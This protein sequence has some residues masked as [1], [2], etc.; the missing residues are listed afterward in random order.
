M[1]AP[2]R[3]CTLG[4][5][6]GILRGRPTAWLVVVVACALTLVAVDAGPGT[7][8][9]TASAE[10]VRNATIV[11]EEGGTRSGFATPE[12]TVGGGGTVTVVNLDSMD[13]TVTSVARAADGTPLF[14]VRVPAGTSATV[15]GVEALSAGAW[16]STASST[17]TCA[18]SSTSRGSPAASSPSTRASSSRWWSPTP[19]GRRHQAGHAPRGGADPPPRAAHV[20]VDLRRQLSRSDHQAA[21]GQG[22]EVTFVNRLPRGAGSMSS[23]LHGDHH[24]SKDD[25]QPTTYLIARGSERTYDYPLVVDGRPEPARSSGT[26]TTGWTAPPAT[27]GAACRACSSS[28]TRP[29][30]GCACRRA[31]RRAADGLRALLHRGNQLTDPF[32][33]GPKMAGHH[34]DMSWT[35]PT[36]RRTTR[37]SATR[38]WSTAAT[39]RT[40]TCRRPAT[41]CGC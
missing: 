20:D 19:P 4:T 6:T 22:T 21:G 9:R 41:A 10:P 8:G 35:G 24:A 29:D 13:H 23:H 1:P 39:R 32:A 38:S 15:P 28:P 11:I 33:D 2:G 7:D 5:M 26:T 18:A 34:G 14:D 27:T 12:V 25:G 36:R 31:P 40:S 3:S 17:P 30:A 37:R 16:A